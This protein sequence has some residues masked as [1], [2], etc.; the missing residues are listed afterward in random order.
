MEKDFSPLE[1]DEMAHAVVIRVKLDPN[2]D[3]EHRHSILNSLV[4]PGAKVLPGFRN[5]IWMNNGAGTGSCVLVFDTKASAQSAVAPM[6][7]EGGPEVLDVEV[8][9]IEIEV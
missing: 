6:T 1:A 8:L 2:S 5:G 7:P 3:I 9:E 4:I